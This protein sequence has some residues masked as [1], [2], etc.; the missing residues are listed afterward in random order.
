M[1]DNVL[2]QTIPNFSASP[3]MF[4]KVLAITASAIF[5][6]ALQQKLISLPLQ[7]ITKLLKA[8]LRAL[9]QDPRWMRRIK[10]GLAASL[11][12][13]AWASAAGD[14]GTYPMNRPGR[15]SLRRQT[16]TAENPGDV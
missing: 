13:F 11:K 4:Y 9:S 8:A 14:V 7:R 16:T 15:F 1:D 6:L 12:R 10:V 2:Q 3:G 5:G